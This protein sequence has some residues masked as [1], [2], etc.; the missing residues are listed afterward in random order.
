MIQNIL[1]D[2]LQESFQILSVVTAK[3]R[4]NLADNTVSWGGKFDDGY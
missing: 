2:F 3:H 4:R 1:S